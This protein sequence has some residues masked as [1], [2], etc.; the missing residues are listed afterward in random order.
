MKH[1]T[2]E[3]II[4][5][6]SAD[7]MNTETLELINMVN[8]HICQCNDCLRKVKAYSIV[9]DGLERE[10]IYSGLDIKAP[11]MEKEIDNF[12]SNNISLDK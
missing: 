3:E 2:D 10:A 1:L 11:E 5:F 7:K 9:N 6:I 12:K 8:T 4:S